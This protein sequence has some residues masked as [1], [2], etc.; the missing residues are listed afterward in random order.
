MLGV[1]GVVALVLFALVFYFFKWLL[2]AVGLI[3]P[4]PPSG[5]AIGQE[6]KYRQGRDSPEAKRCLNALDR[7]T[8][9][10]I[11]E[12]GEMWRVLSFKPTIDNTY[13]FTLQRVE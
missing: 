11:H 4:N 1:L 8:K 13:E 12:N 5:F 2:T 7:M 6:A 9:I 10:S 3:K